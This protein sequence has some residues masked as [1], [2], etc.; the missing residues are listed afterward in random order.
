[1]EDLGV[2]GRDF[3]KLT[4]KKMDGSTRTEVVLFVIGRGGGS[5]KH[6]RLKKLKE[7]F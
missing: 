3:L 6:V 4:L 7:F 5:Y 2:D 1:V